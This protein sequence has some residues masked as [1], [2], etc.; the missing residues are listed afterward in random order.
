[1]TVATN[2]EAR[3]LNA[4]IREERVRAGDVD[5]S[6]TVVGMD[7]LSIGRGD[8]IQTRQ[9]D[10]GLRIANRQVWVVRS[11]GADGSAWAAAINETR[12][13]RTVWMPAEYLAEHTHLSYAATAHGVQGMTVAE[14]HTV[15]SDA[16]GAAGIYVGMTRG[17]DA[18]RVHFVEADVDDAREQFI[19]A[20]QRDRADRGLDSA[21]AAAAEAVHGLASSAV[22]RSSSRRSDLGDFG[23]S[24]NHQAAQGPTLG[25]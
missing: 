23:R 2:D 14:S 3:E 13:H 18:N 16:M 19:L 6:R 7:G 24:S 17:R 4:R 22:T 5:D 12:K 11:V 21:A 8:V 20:A 1:M 15:V 9:N 25:R 10:A